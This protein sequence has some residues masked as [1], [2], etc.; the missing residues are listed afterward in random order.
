MMRKT[1]A[2]LLLTLT[3]TV[4]ACSGYNTHTKI[5]NRWCELRHDDDG[6]IHGINCK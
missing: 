1:F 4:A 6:A 2:L 5:G 3:L